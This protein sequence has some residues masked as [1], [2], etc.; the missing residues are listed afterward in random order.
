[1][2]RCTP[3]FCH[4]II[5]N[6]LSV[7]KILPLLCIALLSLSRSQAQKTYSRWSIGLS[8]GPSFPTGKFAHKNTG[9]VGSG[10]AL[11]GVGAELTAGYRLN[12]TFGLVAIAGWQ[13]NKQ[14]IDQSLI[15]PGTGTLMVVPPPGHTW[16]IAR[17][18]TG[19]SYSYPFSTR[20][21]P[22]LQIRV[23]GGLLKTSIPGVLNGFSIT[24]NPPA[25][26]WTFC[27]Q[28]DA[29][30][31]WKLSPRFSLTTTAGYTGSSPVSHVLISG[32]ALEPAAIPYHYFIGSIQIR[33][34]VEMRL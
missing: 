30:L 1:M 34:G 5:L 32:D 19:V 7:K 14:R 28:A 29:G 16:K 8:A 9:E 10:Y 4:W 26:P 17:L 22:T 24:E 15:V 12:R 33:A 3:I 6:P 25:L 18:L 27:Y 13:E 21:G 23:L 31:K 2:Q 20:S 11:T